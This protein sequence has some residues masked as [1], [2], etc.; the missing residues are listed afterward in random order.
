MTTAEAFAEI[1]NRKINLVHSFDAFWH[2]SVDEK[3][4]TLTTKKRN[5]RTV[6]VMALTPIGAVEALCAKL[7]AIYEQQEMEWVA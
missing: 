2:A 7:D 1:E 5:I 6:S 4:A 3:G